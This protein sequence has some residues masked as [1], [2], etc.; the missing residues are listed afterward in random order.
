MDNQPIKNKP[1]VI[2][3]LP[4]YN[5]GA[6]LRRTVDAIPKNTV[7]DIILVDDKSR[8]D[9]LAVA[10]RLGLKTFAHPEN[11]GYGGNQKTCYQEALALGADIV[12][13][14]HPDFQYDPSFIPKMIKPIANG[15]C[16]A[17][18][19]S[20]MM[21]RKNALDG[22]MPY[23]KFLANIFL[24]KLENFVLRMDLTEYHSGFRAYSRKVLEL[25]LDLNSDNFVF[26]TEI[27]AQ[28]KVAGMSVKEIPISTRYF[29]EASM[30]GFFRSLKYGLSILAVM[31]RYVSFKLGWRRF[32]QFSKAALAEYECPF[33]ASH[34][35]APH[36]LGNKSLEEILSEPY[37]VTEGNIGA[38]AGLYKCSDCGACFTP[39]IA[40]ND[41]IENFYKKAPLDK[42][43]LSDE[44]GRRRTA[45][46]V[47]RTLI[48]YAPSGRLLDICCNTGIF[49]A[50]A[51]KFFNP[52]GT[53]LSTEAA[54]YARANFGLN[55]IQTEPDA[56][57][58]FP[59][60]YFEAITAF[61][62]LE[63]MSEPRAT[64]DAIYGK[65]KPGG[66]LVFTTPNIDSAFARLLGKRWHALLPSHLFF[67]TPK[68]L[69]YLLKTTGFELIKSGSYARF[70]STNYLLR[71]LL[72]DKSFKLPRFLNFVVPVNFRD[73]M[74]VYLRKPL[75]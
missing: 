57:I 35:L 56:L 3:V 14:V 20:R 28:M 11:R 47:L 15:E 53:E 18:F 67:F 54:G 40:L 52:Y 10:R 43:Y 27:I 16:D 24:T 69:S 19:G 34:R 58:S 22:G 59:N 8:D 48:K 44:Y 17:V 21:V 42:V 30:I 74:E 41:E 38:C 63:H 62:V 50:E 9:T 73:E 39:Q 55:N 70:F 45:R 25:P 61:D 7:D 49:L 12:V 75:S 29:P 36:F 1:K 13:M 71:R 65:L 72:K 23:W 26:D 6:T 37:F 60:N 31:A 2:V 4:A 46:R 51:Q 5:A 66:V 64:L 32:P 68:T 33:C